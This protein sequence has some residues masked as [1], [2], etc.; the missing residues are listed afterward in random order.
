MEFSQGFLPFGAYLTDNFDYADRPLPTEQDAVRELLAF[1]KAAP[2]PQAA[3]VKA[4]HDF[5]GALLPLLPTVLALA[6]EPLSNL[7]FAA[8]L[9][10]SVLQIPDSPSESDLRES[11]PTFL[12][13][14]PLARLLAKLYFQGSGAYPP[15][16]LRA[17]LAAAGPSVM[18]ARIVEEAL[19]A[20][21]AAP[22]CPAP[23]TSDSDSASA[24]S[25]SPPSDSAPSSGATARGSSASG[26]HASSH[27]LL[28]LPPTSVSLSPLERGSKLRELI[29]ALYADE[30]IPL[31]ELGLL[32]EGFGICL[33][34]AVVFLAR[35]CPGETERLSEEVASAA[36]WREGGLGGM[37][38]CEACEMLA[39]E[40]GKLMRAEEEEVRDEW[41]EWWGD[42]E[43]W[44]ELE[45]A[46]D[47][48]NKEAKNKMKEEVVEDDGEVLWEFGAEEG[49]HENDEAEESETGENEPEV[50]D[51]AF[52]PVK[53][54][55]PQG[56]L[57]WPQGKI[58][59]PASPINMPDSPLTWVRNPLYLPKNSLSLP[60]SPLSWPRK[61]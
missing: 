41:G 47:E 50:N 9:I 42:K 27:T 46:R 43:T 39:E 28:S 2:K 7:E 55:W 11:Q 10:R 1:V 32:L 53:L 21:A 56:R 19:L 37:C 48:A 13:H 54:R 23:P 31:S 26:S 61:A 12:P 24:S 59:W 6:G 14:A 17:A 58:A 22:L 35:A 51:G 15:A 44:E 45:R 5:D 29:A 34:W 52:R 36:E 40:K 3:V 18:R 30:G 25:E 60:K 4:Y 57:Y 49:E 8:L 20:H 16:T 33:S 38:G